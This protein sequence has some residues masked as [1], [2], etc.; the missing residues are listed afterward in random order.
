MF[1]PG[2]LRIFNKINAPVMS[3]PLKVITGLFLYGV[4]LLLALTTVFYLRD[5]S[6]RHIA[7]IYSGDE[8]TVSVVLM[9]ESEMRNIMNIAL[10]SPEVER[11]LTR[12]GYGSGSKLLNYIVPRD[13]YLAD[14]PLEERP[15]GIHGHHQPKN[16]N[17]KKYKILFT[18]AK[19]YSA[20]SVEGSEIIK[21]T[22]GRDPLVVVKVDSANGNI[23]SIEIPPA[24]VLWGDIPTPLF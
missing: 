14:L 23:S 2:D 16:F 20:E 9:S 4:I 18:K 13:W 22:Y 11:I 5:Y 15:E 10:K 6:L 7:T 21:F 3:A 8:A 12:E 17:R 19:L 1:L 24:H